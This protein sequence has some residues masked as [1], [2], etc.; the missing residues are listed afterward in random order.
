[1]ITYIEKKRTNVPYRIFSACLAFTFFFT[2]VIPPDAGYAQTIPQTV[3][4]LPVPG[5]ILPISDGFTPVIV[6]G[7]SLYPDNPLKF[8]FLIDKGDTDFL[9]KELKQEST[10]LIKYFLAS[11]TVPE[12]ELW[13][14]LSPYEGDRIIPAG[15][16]ITEMGRDLLSQDYI[17]KQLMASLTYPE[18]G[19]GKQF[20]DRVYKKAYEL[21]GTTDIPLDTFNKVWIVP[22]KAIVYEHGRSVFVVKS[23]LKVMLEEDYLALQSNLGNTR[24]GVNQLEETE[25]KAISKVSSDV[26]R[27]VLI[28][29]IE[30]EVNNGKN[31]SN[32]RQI[33]HS[34]LLATWYKKNLRESLLGQVYVDKNKT[35]G[36]DVEDK[37]DSGQNNMKEK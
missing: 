21:Y 7:L 28:P 10:K 20:W 37:K 31:F 35:K 33:Y 18:S 4:N 6:K 2:L 30:E 22:E 15:L 36:V 17:L 32:L 11:L 9:D 29:E 3:L 24:H 8:D 5:S 14:N 25:V 23:D 26:V 13:V 19:L 12:K 34:M 27:D 16:G 1:M